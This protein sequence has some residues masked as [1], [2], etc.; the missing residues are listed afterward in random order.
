[1]GRNHT[2]PHLNS[3]LGDYLQKIKCP[4]CDAEILILPDLKRMNQAI[5]EHINKEH[6]KDTPQA[7]LRRMKIRDSLSNQVLE[8]LGR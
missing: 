6:S 3:F 7:I 8:V 2:S 1:M 5:E 4:D